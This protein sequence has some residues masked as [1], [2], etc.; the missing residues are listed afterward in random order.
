MVKKEAEIH[1]FNV[2][3]NIIEKTSDVSKKG[4]YSENDQLLREAGKKLRFT[5]PP[6]FFVTLDENVEETYLGNRRSAL[7]KAIELK[8]EKS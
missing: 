1:S 4:S 3:V 7:S 8:R 2:K 6:V 5:Y